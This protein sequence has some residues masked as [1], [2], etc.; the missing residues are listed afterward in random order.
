MGAKYDG[1]F[2]GGFLHGSGTLVGFDG[3]NYSG[4]WR[5]N[6]QHGLGKKQY[7]NSDVY[8]GL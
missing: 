4:S 6:I 5:M 8:E 2:L 7:C 1:D 3:S